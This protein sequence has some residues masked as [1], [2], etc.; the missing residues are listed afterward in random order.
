MEIN[1]IEL[2]REDRERD[3]ERYD[4]GAKVPP[5]VKHSLSVSELREKYAPRE[6]EKVDIWAGCW[7][8]KNGELHFSTGFIKN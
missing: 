5:K 6:K 7:R 4:D 8:D 2:L 3:D 1:G